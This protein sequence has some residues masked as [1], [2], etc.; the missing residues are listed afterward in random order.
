VGITSWAP[1]VTVFGVSI[2]A[3]VE[4]QGTSQ[5]ISRYGAVTHNLCELNAW[6][7]RLPQHDRLVTSNIDFLINTCEE[8]YRGEFM[9]WRSSSSAAQALHKAMQETPGAGTGVSTSA[10]VTTVSMNNTATAPKK[11]ATDIPV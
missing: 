5:K 3:L 11:V 1:I 7:E 8:L 2:N 9:A 10:P 4:F 6:W